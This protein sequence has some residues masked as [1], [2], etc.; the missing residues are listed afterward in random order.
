MFLHL[1]QD[2]VIRTDEIVGIFD[3]ESSSISKHTRA[4]L[5]QAEKQGVVV[6][7]TEELP[8]CFV[9]CVDREGCRKIYIT[10]ISST[11]LLK[12]ARFRKPISSM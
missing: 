2:T 4:Y 10:Q 5:S 8:K 11:T 6:N 9:L 12:R 3:L 1:G 7:V